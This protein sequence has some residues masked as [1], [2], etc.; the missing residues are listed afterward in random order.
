MQCYNIA[1]IAEIKGGVL[2][3]SDRKGCCW[4]MPKFIP[5]EEVI[6]RIPQGATLMVGG[7][8]GCG[9]PH[10]VI[11]A[12]AESGK[13]EFTLICNDGALFNGPDGSE[14]YGVAKLIR[15]HQ[16]KRLIASHVGLNPEV[17]RQRNAGMLQVDLLPQGSFVEMIRAGGSGLGGVLTPTGVGT[18]V[19]DSPFVHSKVEVDGKQFLL[20]RPLRADIA[21]VSGYY[22]DRKGNIW[23]RGTT[24][25]FN[26][27]MALAADTVIAEADYIVDCGQIA[28]ENV[29]TPGILVDYVVD[30]GKMK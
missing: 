17:G 25:N 2:R 13:G 3:R 24:R 4:I 7:F 21:L 12:L 20:M 8:M 15:N 26:Q 11:S 6:A 27:V 9:N 14:C 29:V 5:A 19:E 30:G 23:Y 28:P 1:D 22:I 18:E 10:K 16:V